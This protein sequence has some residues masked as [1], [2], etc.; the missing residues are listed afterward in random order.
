MIEF[1]LYFCNSN[2][3]VF[4][5]QKKNSPENEISIKI[6]MLFKISRG[7][8]RASC[9][10]HLLTYESLKFIGDYESKKFSYYDSFRNLL[11]VTRNN[12]FIFISYIDVAKNI[13]FLLS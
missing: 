1:F 5:T 11:T 3:Q 8:K 13:L 9:Y 12:L 4:I 7:S 6:F 2:T 10:R